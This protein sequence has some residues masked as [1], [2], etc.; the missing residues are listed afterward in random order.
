MLQTD[1][2]CYFGLFSEQMKTLIRLGSSA[3]KLDVLG[4]H[5]V[6]VSE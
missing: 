4:Y 5:G 2:I 3:G 6:S 1:F